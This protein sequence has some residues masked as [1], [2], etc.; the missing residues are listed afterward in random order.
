M[1]S[2]WLHFSK[3]QRFCLLHDTLITVWYPCECG[4]AST[5]GSTSFA[6]SISKAAL[7]SSDNSMKVCRW[8]YQTL[9]FNGWPRGQKSVRLGWIDC[10]SQERI[11]GLSSLSGVRVWDL[12][13]L[14]VPTIPAILGHESDHCSRCFLWRI[15]IFQ[16]NA[17]SR[18]H[19]LVNSIL[20]GYYQCV[21]LAFVKRLRYRPNNP[22]RN[23]I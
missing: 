12:R 21:H 22:A 14:S 3:T 10:A 18:L 1:C 2:V 20:V 13:Q 4:R 5:G 15:H 17:A 23:A 11:E 6:F 16:M 8:P 9:G 7:T 19:R